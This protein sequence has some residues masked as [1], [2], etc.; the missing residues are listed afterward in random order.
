MG[1][2]FLCSVCAEAIASKLGSHRFSVCPPVGARLAREADDS[3]A[4]QVR[5]PRPLTSNRAQATYS[6]TVATIM[7]VIATLILM[8]DTPRMP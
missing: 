5:M 2:R 3:V 1:G 8:S 7:K 6:T 4:D